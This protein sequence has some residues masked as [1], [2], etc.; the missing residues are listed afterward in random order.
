MR[1]NLEEKINY[2]TQNIRKS[3]N[4]AYNRNSIMKNN[5]QDVNNK[6]RIRRANI[7]KSNGNWVAKAGKGVTNFAIKS[8][9]AFGGATIGLSAGVASGD[10][11]NTVKFTRLRNRSR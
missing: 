7:L 1:T 6:K 4:E 9:G 3:Q 2:G 10:L 11:A 5:I 8:A